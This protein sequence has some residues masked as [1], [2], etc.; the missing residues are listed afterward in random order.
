MSDLNRSQRESF[1]VWLSDINQICGA[2]DGE[3]SAPNFSA[4]IEE[5][6]QGALKMSVV[7]ASHLCLRRQQREVAQVS[8][9][10]YYAVFQL[11]G[12]ACMAQ[13]EARETLSVGEIMFID[14]ARPSA[15]TYS[16]A[17]RQLSLILPYDLVG[18]TLPHRRIAGGHKIAA[19][20]AVAGLAA[21]LLLATRAQGELSVPES[22]AVLESTL[23]LLRPALDASPQQVDP[24]ERIFRKG[25]ELI[26]RHIREAELSP[27]FVAQEIGVSMR[28][29]YRIF[30]KHGLVVAQYIKHRRLDLCAQALRQGGGSEKLA[31]V[32]YSWGFSNSSY[33]T[34]AF[35]ARF[36]VSP[37]EYRKRCH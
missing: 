7:D 36:G 28:G 15:F 25:L 2:F 6:C 20:M 30:A 31:V 5:Y 23:N 27:E 18:H 4:R 19:G 3:A 9:H 10:H 34:T 17:S 12:S 21:Q 35:K 37:S 24:H 26:E 32:G 8:S 11:A 1:A 33:F 22:E 16:D 14:N 29:L 13:G